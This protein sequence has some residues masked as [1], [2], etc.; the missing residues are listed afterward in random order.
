MEAIGTIFLPGE[1]IPSAYW[2]KEVRETVIIYYLM[3]NTRI[4]KNLTNIKEKEEVNV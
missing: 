3:D 1:I 2:M 4:I